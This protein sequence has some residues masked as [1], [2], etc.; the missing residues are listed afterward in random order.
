MELIHGNT[1]SSKEIAEMTG[2]RH[3]HVMRDIRNIENNLATPDLGALWTLGT[4]L[5]S[6]QK[7]RPVYHLT[8]KGSLLLATKY[9]DEIR[10]KLI[11]RWE[12]LETQ[13]ALPNAKQLAQMVIAAEEEK[14]RLLAENSLKDRT[15]QLQAP[16]VEYH[17]QVLQSEGTYNTNHIAKELGM[18]AISLNRKLKDLGV[19]YKQGG[20]WLLYRSHQDKGYTKTKTYTYIDQYGVQS[21]AMQTV[22]TEKGRLFIHNLLKQGDVA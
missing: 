2:K 13:T 20:V 15:I 10:L 18:S 11:N 5:D 1:I 16:K 3:D 14:E 22:W 7:R 19:Q 4:Q 17:D 8:K 12:E 21:T 9:S 6:Q